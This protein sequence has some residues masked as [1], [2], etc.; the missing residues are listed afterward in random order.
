GA[1]WTHHAVG[2]RSGLQPRLRHHPRQPRYHLRRGRA[3]VRVGLGPRE[4]LRGDALPRRCLVAVLGDPGDPAP[5]RE[6]GPGLAAQGDPD[7][8]HEPMI[9]RPLIVIKRIPNIDF[10]GLHKLGFA[11]S[12]VLTVASVALFLTVGLNYGIDFSGGVLVEARTQ[13]PADL[14]T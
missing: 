13:G 8:G 2:A 1:G 11:L 12:L 6:L 7:L 10:M 9:L 14:G 4:R 5:D 3:D